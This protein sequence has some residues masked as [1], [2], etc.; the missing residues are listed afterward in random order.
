MKLSCLFLQA[1]AK[2]YEAGVKRVKESRERIKLSRDEV[3]VMSAKYQ[4]LVDRIS[5]LDAA[6]QLKTTALEQ[7]T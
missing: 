3:S 5:Q 7:V 4:Q 6:I 1:I 2:R